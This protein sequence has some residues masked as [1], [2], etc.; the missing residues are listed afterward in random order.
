M[1]MDKLLH[2]FICMCIVLVVWALLPVG[3]WSIVFACVTAL[4]VGIGK[5]IFDYTKVGSMKGIDYKDI[6]A[7]VLGIIGG[8]AVIMLNQMIY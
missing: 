3:T 6:I 8:L 1:F 7:D 4:G 5:E 2:F